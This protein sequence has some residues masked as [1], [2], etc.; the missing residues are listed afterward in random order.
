MAPD[1]EIAANIT[2]FSKVRT[3]IFDVT[4]AETEDALEQ[5][6]KRKTQQD[7]VI[8]DGH[9]DTAGVSVSRTQCHHLFSC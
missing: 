8:W 3:D 6:K 5:R 9:A 7:K 1:D 4:G 2:A